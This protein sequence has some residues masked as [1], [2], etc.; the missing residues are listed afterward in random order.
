MTISTHFWHFRDFLT[1]PSLKRGSFYWK[2]TRFFTKIHCFSLIFTVFQWSENL[3]GKWRKSRKWLKTVIFMK[4]SRKS[5]QNRSLFRPFSQKP[6]LSSVLTRGSLKRGSFWLKT[7]ILT[8][9]R[10]SAGT[11]KSGK[12][13]KTV[14]FSDFRDFHC[15]ALF[16]HFLWVWIGVWDT[17]NRC[18]LAKKGVKKC[19][20]VSFWQKPLGL[21]K[22]LDTLGHHCSVDTENG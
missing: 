8:K 11:P 5:V 19:Q 1:P 21:D 9:L 16:R 4:I 3:M 7:S 14:I 6:G 17:P 20:K 18:T 12:T 10:G 2:W 15:F 22:G 13:R